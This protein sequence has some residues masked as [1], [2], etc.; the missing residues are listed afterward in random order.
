MWERERPSSNVEDLSAKDRE[1]NGDAGPVFGLRAI[2]R[3]EK[4]ISWLHWETWAD[5]VPRDSRRLT[6]NATHVSFIMT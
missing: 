6:F 4:D 2:R 1:E 5:L 3:T